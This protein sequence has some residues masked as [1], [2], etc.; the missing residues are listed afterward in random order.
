MR[1]VLRLGNGP[2]Q[3]LGHAVL[4]HGER[5]RHARLAEILLSDDV[6]GDL[7]PARGTSTFSC[8]NTMVPSGLRISDVVVVNSIAVVCILPRLGKLSFDFHRTPLFNV[9]SMAGRQKPGEERCRLT[10]C[11]HRACAKA[12]QS[13]SPM[14]AVSVFP[15]RRTTCSGRSGS[16]LHKWRK[17]TASRQRFFRDFAIDFGLTMTGGTRVVIQLRTMEGI[18]RG[19]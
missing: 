17:T 7:A 19:K 8:R 14:F 13:L 2:P 1:G 5:G 9:Q 16:C 18:C 6:G 11:V 12:P 15:C 10:P 3:E 4:A